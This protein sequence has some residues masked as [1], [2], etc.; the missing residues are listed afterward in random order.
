MNQPDCRCKEISAGSASAGAHAGLSADVLF[1]CTGN[2][3]RSRFA[4]ELFNHFAKENGLLRRA[5]SLGF[6]PHP[7][8]NP[9]PMSVFALAALAAR[10]VKPA[11]AERFPVAVRAEDFARYPLIIALSETEHRP[12]MERMFPQFA[13][14]VHYW[15]AEDL[16]WEA[17]ANATA[18]IERE[19]RKLL[20]IRGVFCRA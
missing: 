2:Y 14:L 8:V 19:V 10:G 5:D 18:K 20:E 11:A 12:M 9:G 13:P 17:P 4:E 15:Q 16:A 1:L 6:T 3:Y 7:H